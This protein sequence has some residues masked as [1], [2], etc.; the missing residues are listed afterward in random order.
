MT[1]HRTDL[2]T[3]G[4]IAVIGAVYYIATFSIQETANIVTPRTFPAI[5][6]IGLIVLGLFLAGQAVVRHRKDSL[7]EAGPGSSGSA[8]APAH[9]VG[10]GEGAAASAGESSL[11]SADRSSGQEGVGGIVLEAPPEPQVR[12]VVFQF[13]LFFVYLAILIPVGFLLST[14][15][16]L[17]GLTSI[18]ARE[19][20][21]RNLIFSV[22]FSV[23]VYAAFV[24][25]LAVYLPVGILG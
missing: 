13:A 5:V 3:G 9:A 20:W 23:V 4:A 1:A 14:A 7:A 10:D 24:Y 18:Y 21:I 2:I 8:P 17:M 11:E 12:K 15:A 16:F 22:L 19:K 25:G 6:G